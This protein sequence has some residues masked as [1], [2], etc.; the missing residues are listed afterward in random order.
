MFNPGHLQ[1]DV[2]P[3]PK[4]ARN[5]GTAYQGFSSA[6]FCDQALNPDPLSRSIMPRMSDSG[7]W[8]YS[9]TG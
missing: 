5:I 1:K 9:L 7:T 2:L 6:L 4:Q 3:P 8:L